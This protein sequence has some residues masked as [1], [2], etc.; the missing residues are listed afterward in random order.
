MTPPYSVTVCWQYIEV[1]DILKYCKKRNFPSQSFIGV[2]GGWCYIGGGGGCIEFWL[3][4]NILFATIDEMHFIIGLYGWKNKLPNLYIFKYQILTPSMG[5]FSFLSRP[6]TH[7]QTDRQ[8]GTL[9][10]R[11]LVFVRHSVTQKLSD[12]THYWYTEHWIN[13]AIPVFARSILID[14][15][16]SLFGGCPL[17]TMHCRRS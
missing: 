15:S 16:T 12:L 1:V 13:S 7:R 17:E 3:Y 14:K 5:K 11:F 9:H 2:K 4:E 10:D 8:T 6:Q